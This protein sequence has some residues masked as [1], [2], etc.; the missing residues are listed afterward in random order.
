[1]SYREDER[2]KVFKISHLCFRLGST[3]TLEK[4]FLRG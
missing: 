3:L 2:K 1:M 4:I